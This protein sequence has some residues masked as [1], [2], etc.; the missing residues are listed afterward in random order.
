[1]GIRKA[2]YGFLTLLLATLFVFPLTGIFTIQAEEQ[3]EIDV[4]VEKVVYELPFPGILPDHPFYVMKETRD[5]L[6]VFLTRDH[7][8]KS[9]LLLLISDK[10]TAMAVSL[11]EEG[12]WKSSAEAIQKAETAFSDMIVVMQEGKEQGV[13]PS[14]G[15]SKQAE[16]SNK[17]HAE[18]IMDI[19]MD[20][21][22]GTRTVLQ[23]ALEMNHDSA[24]LLQEF[25]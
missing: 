3:V 10:Y 14:D 12:Q 18:I 25:N 5:S 13:S 23:E 24:E 6:M 17:K 7:V 9:E 21:P 15:L 1:M 16:T 19:L 2:T 11:S 4:D 22:N 20:S 8:K